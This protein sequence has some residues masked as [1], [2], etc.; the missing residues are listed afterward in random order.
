MW[1]EEWRHGEDTAPD[2]QIER[3]PR[4]SYFYCNCLPLSPSLLGLSPT[5]IPPQLCKTHVIQ[6]ISAV[7][8]DPQSIT[9]DQFLNFFHIWWHCH[10][11]HK[12]LFWRVHYINPHFASR[13]PV[14]CWHIFLVSFIYVIGVNFL[15]FVWSLGSC[16][17]WVIEVRERSTRDMSPAQ[18][19]DYIGISLIV[20]IMLLSLHPYLP[21]SMPFGF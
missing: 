13:K 9:Y 18:G 15:Y 21:C 6:T 11:G 19:D 2:G 17:M 1:D 12:N 7:S 3:G 14:F 4:E 16:K 10:P 8:N 20:H 5:C